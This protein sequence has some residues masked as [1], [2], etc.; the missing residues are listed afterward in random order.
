M[1]TQAFLEA[2][3]SVGVVL[4]LA[5]PGFIFTKKKILT[6][7]Q[8][9]GISSVLVNFLWPAMV[10]DAMA[11]ARADA[12]LVR[13]AGQAALW[14]LGVIVL[15]ALCAWI[16]LKVGK[17]G[18]EPG[19]ILLFAAAFANTGLIGMPLIRLLLGEKMLFL[20]SMVEL[21][22]D[23]LI[24]SVGILL[25]Q[26]GCGKPR[27]AALRGLLSPG[28]AGVA[29]GFL[30]F[31]TGWKLPAFAGEAL[32]MAADATAPMVLF[33]VGAQLG[34]GDLR[35]LV[36]DGRAWLLTALR[37]VVVPAAV[38]A[39]WLIFA[40][41]LTAVGQTILLLAAMPAG[42]CCAMFTRQYG[43]DWGLATRC[44]MLSTLCAVV[45]V[46]LWLLVTIL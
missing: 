11:Q 34:E 12:E 32:S 26:T 44:V 23:V 6:S 19:G 13:Q 1:R 7:R 2:V 27:R 22:N 40:G 42:S 29:V 41:E 36:R 5:V 8:V 20:A 4:L 10:V 39:L 45:T 35:A 30:L 16:W 24:F 18:S 3:S 37:L 33:L 25:I 15:G 31:A 43:G 17:I 38:L 21:V 9:E 28:L 14:A 46:P